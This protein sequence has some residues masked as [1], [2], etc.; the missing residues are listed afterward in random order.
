MTAIISLVRHHRRA[1]RHRRLRGKGR[2]TSSGGKVPSSSLVTLAPLRLEP[3]SCLSQ[4][5][6]P[7]L[8]TSLLYSGHALQIIFHHGLPTLGHALESPRAREGGAALMWT[9]YL[10]SKRASF[11]H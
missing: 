1:R 8:S 11:L 5:S 9:G 3:A 2:W 4:S 10:V 6:S 7:F